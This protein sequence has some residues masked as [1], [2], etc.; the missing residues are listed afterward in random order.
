[1]NI[2]IDTN[3]I[4]DHLLDRKPYAHE[5]KQVIAMIETGLHTGFLCATTITT[6]DYLIRKV[7]G[8]K[9][10]KVV[11]N[12]L[13]NL[14]EI[15]AVNRVVLETALVSKFT[16]FEDAVLHESAKHANLDAIITRNQADFKAAKL[17]IYSPH[18]FLATL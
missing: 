5:S 8:N 7:V 2:L 12:D 6:L 15:T 10:A 16:D 1:M 17:A 13:F 11:L 3:V 4:L 9:E 14:F 18:E